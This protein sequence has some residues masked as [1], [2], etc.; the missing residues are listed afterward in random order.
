MLQTTTKLDQCCT[1]LIGIHCFC[2]CTSFPSLVFLHLWTKRMK[3]NNT[4][5][6]LSNTKISSGS[7]YSKND[8][9]FHASPQHSHVIGK[10]KDESVFNFFA[11]LFWFSKSHDVMPF[12]VMHLNVPHCLCLLLSFATVSDDSH[13]F[14]VL[15]FCAC[16]NYLR[17]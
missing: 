4:Y 6:C 10:R 11:A 17:V 16:L 1:I 14:R 3:H 15:F 7:N 5:L 13:L 12:G 8:R 2:I 9:L